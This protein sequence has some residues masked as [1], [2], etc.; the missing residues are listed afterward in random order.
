MSVTVFGERQDRKEFVIYQSWG[1]IHKMQIQLQVLRLG[2][3]QLFYPTLEYNY[4]YFIRYIYLLQ[5]N[6]NRT[7]QHS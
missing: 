3:L 7:Q 1:Q 2:Q 4:N 6:F 5:M